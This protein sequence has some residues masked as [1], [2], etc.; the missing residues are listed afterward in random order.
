MKKLLEKCG[1]VA[2]IAAAGMV[3]ASS[4]A[5]AAT[6]NFACSGLFC[7]SSSPAFNFSDDGIGVSVTGFVNGDPTMQRKVN[8]SIFGLGVLG[9]NLGTGQVDSGLF[10]IPET[11]RL[12]FDQTVEALVAEF[13]LVGEP[14]TSGTDSVKVIFDG[15]NTIFEGVIPSTGGFLQ[16]FPG[17]VSF[18]AGDTGTQ[19]DFTVSD[20]DDGFRLYSVEAIAAQPAAVPEPASIL[21]LLVLGAVGA[22]TKRNKVA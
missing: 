4:S 16:A 20:P 6:Y 18:L 19:L 1:I 12:T 15:V 10:G 17:T 11:L 21:G 14:F 5:Q 3:V 9:G 7:S 8:Q 2:A 13:R 22:T